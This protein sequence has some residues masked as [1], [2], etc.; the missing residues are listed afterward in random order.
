MAKPKKV[1]NP[2]YNKVWVRTALQDVLSR[3]EIY[4]LSGGS[5]KLIKDVL[6]ICDKKAKE[7]EK[8]K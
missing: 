2:Q 7:K 8:T 5:H 6:S 1:W 3:H 4:G